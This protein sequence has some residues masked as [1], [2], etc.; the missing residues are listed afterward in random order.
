MNTT[1]TGQT[2]SR[3]REYLDLWVKLISEHLSKFVHYDLQ[4]EMISFE[5]ST[6][7]LGVKSDNGTWIRF[8]GAS[9]G[10]QAFFLDSQGS[11]R[12]LQLLG[13]VS[14]GQGNGQSL[15]TRRVL[16]DFFSRI[17]AKIPLPEWVGS[18]A[19]LKV[20]G[21]EGPAWESPVRA[22][23]RFSSSQ[24]ALLVLH[25]LLSSDF[26]SALQSAQEADEPEKKGLPAIDSSLFRAPSEPVHDTRLGLLMD[27]E[28]EVVL[29]FGQ[30]EMLLCD[31]LGLTPGTVLELD[32]QVQDPVE[33]LVGNK[34][35]AW[36]EVVTV[37]GNYGLRVTS[38]A[39]REDRL[40]FLRK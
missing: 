23:F 17:A 21:A 7:S 22:V 40:D 38:L 19:E 10:E 5:E 36:G 9:V 13:D 14:T 34:V 25:A 16:E 27:V 11:I 4:A 3:A 20:S 26:A 29:R 18:D 32:Q 39:S 35:I 6:G 28:L 15:D 31:V 1:D 37:D 24:N 12:L 33:L 30:R 8:A 2:T